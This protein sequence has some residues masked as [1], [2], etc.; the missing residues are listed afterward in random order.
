[1]EFSA[2]DARHYPVVGVREGYA[3]WV[4]TYED[5]VHDEM[6]LALLRRVRTVAWASVG[7]AADL[8]CGTGRTGRWLV[9]QGV[10]RI[11]GLDLT[12]E[13]VA[14]ARD[15]AVY[16]RLAVADMRATP[17]VAQGYDLAMEVLACEHI[18]DLAPLYREAARI[19]RPGGHFV[20]VGYHP[21][22]LLNG[23]PTHFNRAD[24][25]PV[26]IEV[27]VHLLSDHVKAAMA[28]GFALAEMDERVVDDGFV[29][30]KP[31]WAK[32]RDRPVSFCMVWTAG[33]GIPR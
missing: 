4:A 11:D 31:K 17:L 27:Y 28:A 26:A 19:V 25:N 18:P 12:P 13:M 24:G 21:H 6:D 2:F 33:A 5:V 20:V 30:A 9:G 7:R 10:R 1:M 29:A 16:Q 8:A 22:F 15:R 32:Y 14:V 3:E 23:I